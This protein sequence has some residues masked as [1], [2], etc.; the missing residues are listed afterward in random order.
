MTPEANTQRNNQRLLLFAAL[1]GYVAV[2][3]IF[4]WQ[5]HQ[6]FEGHG[7]FGW[8]QPSSLDLVLL[9][10]TLLVAAI[11]LGLAVFALAWLVG[12]LTSS[13]SEFPLIFA[14]YG[15]VLTAVELDLAWYSLARE[16]VALKDVEAFL[17]EDWV[18]H[19][20]VSQADVFK[21]ITLFAIHMGALGVIFLISLRWLKRFPVATLVPRAGLA[22]GLAALFIVDVAATIHYANPVSDQ[23]QAVAKKN[24]LAPGFVHKI[25]ANLASSDDSLARVNTEFRTLAGDFH[26]PHSAT[27]PSPY[28]EAVDGKPNVLLVVVEGFNPNLFDSESMPYLHAFASR[29]V[30]GLRHY[31]TG[32]ITA[33]GLLGMVFGSPLDFYHGQD[34]SRASVSPY[35]DALNHGGYQSSLYTDPISDYRHMG[36]Y[37][38]NFDG[39]V[40]ES[41]DHWELLPQVQAQLSAPGAQFVMTY[42]YGTHYRY[43]HGDQWAHFQP[44]V[45]EN[46]DYTSPELHRYQAEVIN[47]YKNCL[48]EADA[49]FETLLAGVDLENTV[50]VVTGDHGEE[51]FENGRL[52]HAATLEEPQIRTPLIVHTPDGRNAQIAQVTS[53]LDIMPTVLDVVGLPAPAA[54]LGRSIFNGSRQS[55]AIVAGN[56]G[57][58]L[59]K[60]WAVITDQHKVQYQWQSEGYLNVAGVYTREDTRV[61]D[62][63]PDMLRSNLRLG[64]LLEER[65][66]QARVFDPT[67]QNGLD[68]AGSNLATPEL[69][70]DHAHN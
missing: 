23:W 62:V 47:R 4:R 25:V 36:L 56:N 3:S 13:K 50:V 38:G 64:V 11:G 31:S 22:A 14:L 10:N 1:T 55:Y 41:T 68:I 51:F 70:G 61:A 34:A 32:N 59:P 9:C 15:L 46:F 5:H 29:S 52:S 67:Q 8:V 39:A 24:P 43:E 40:V 27:V 42:Y 37:L 48:R 35:I 30:H 44:E 6:V 28:T 21:Y 49:W 65:L 66:R 17:V 26:S 45:P 16:H 57:R 69:E 19:F 58:R 33:Y 20:G 53:H 63:H 2:N 12:R 54:P 7:P 18:A 60:S